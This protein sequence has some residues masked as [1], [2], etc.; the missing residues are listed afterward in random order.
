MYRFFNQRRSIKPVSMA[1]ASPQLVWQLVKNNNCYL[2]R[3]VNNTWFST[4]PGNL[5]GK[6]SYKY[7]GVQQVACD[8]SLSKKRHVNAV[9]CSIA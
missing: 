7:S 1:N 9:H 5:A 4:E 6:N 8:N 2:R 3:N